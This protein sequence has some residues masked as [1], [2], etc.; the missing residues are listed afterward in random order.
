MVETAGQDGHVTEATAELDE[1]IAEIRA[2]K[3]ASEDPAEREQ[4]SVELGSLE[5]QALC[6]GA[7]R[8]AHP[9]GRPRR[10]LPVSAS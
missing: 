6:R 9:G 1:R 5:Q 8:Y 3:G 10:P 2:Q 4:L 7:A